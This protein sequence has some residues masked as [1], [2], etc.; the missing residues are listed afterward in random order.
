[1]N[2][3][4]DDVDEQAPPQTPTKLDHPE[5]WQHWFLIC[6]AFVWNYGGRQKWSHVADERM[7]MVQWKADIL[8]VWCKQRKVAETG[9]KWLCHS[10]SDVL[11]HSHADQLL[12][13][14]VH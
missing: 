1:M 14:H 2:D 5:K 4:H 6:S 13:K 9:E 12:Q 7:H 11:T 8:Q 3:E 10:S